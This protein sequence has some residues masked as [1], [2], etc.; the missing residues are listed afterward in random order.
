VF[1]SGRLLSCFVN[2]NNDDDDY[3]NG[4]Y[5]NDDESVMSVIGSQVGY[6]YVYIV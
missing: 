4:D 5:D 3:Y 1:V 2:N 6:I